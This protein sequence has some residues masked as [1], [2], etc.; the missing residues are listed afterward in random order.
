VVKNLQN[1]S[2]NENILKHRKESIRKISDSINF[3]YPLLI[4]ERMKNAWRKLFKISESESVRFIHALES[5]YFIFYSPESSQFIDPTNWSGKTDAMQYVIESGGKFL[6]LI[7]DYQTSYTSEFSFDK[8]DY[9]QLKYLG[10]GAMTPK[11]YN[12][13]TF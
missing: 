4:D 3:I 9:N 11:F 7:E 2:E 8:K 5:S 6:T 12:F 10:Q 1:L 13:S